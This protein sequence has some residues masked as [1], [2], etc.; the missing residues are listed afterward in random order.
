[1]LWISMLVLIVIA[2]LWWWRRSSRAKRRR[3]RAPMAW[4]LQATG[5]RAAA[6]EE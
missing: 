2:A 5:R 6:T 1:V 3:A 4:L